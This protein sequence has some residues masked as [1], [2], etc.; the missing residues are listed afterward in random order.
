MTLF[1]SFYNSMEF[2]RYHQNVW[3]PLFSL[4]HLRI[5]DS[6]CPS[7]NDLPQAVLVENSHLNS[8]RKALDTGET[9]Y[10]LEKEEGIFAQMLG[11]FR[12]KMCCW[13]IL[14]AIETILVLVLAVLA[15]N[16]F[17]Q[18]GDTKSQIFYATCVLL[19]GMVMLLLKLWS[20]M[21]MNRYALQREI[22]RLELRILELGKRD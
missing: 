13:A 3:A 21:Q 8:I 16:K 11:L 4:L 9:L 17:F 19:L 14:V 5:I 22:K 1:V 10:D 12:G 6:I 2:R 18:A 7:E 20:W 15:A